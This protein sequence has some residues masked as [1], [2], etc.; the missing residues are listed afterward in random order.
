MNIWIAGAINPVV[1]GGVGRSMCNMARELEDRG[2]HIR[3]IYAP[4]RAL[5]HNYLLFSLFLAM[6]LCVAGS[7]K[8]SWII[9]RSTDTFFALL[10]AR[11]FCKNTRIALH[12]HGW[13]EMAYALEARLPNFIVQNPTTWKAHLIRFPVLRFLVK[14]VDACLCG[15]FSE[16][17][18]LAQKYPQCKSRLRY[19]PNGILKNNYRL[20]SGATLAKENPVFLCVGSTTWKKNISYA[21]A[22]FAHIHEEL[23]LA[24]LL[25]IGCPQSLLSQEIAGHSRA[26]DAITLIEAQSFATMETW[27]TKATYLLAT[28]RFEGGH[29]F[30]ILEAM[31][32][33]CI[34]IASDIP[35]H[36]E[37]IQ[38]Q[39]NGFIINGIAPHADA[40]SV[41]SHV[42]H[43]EYDMP[44]PNSS[45]LVEQN[46][47]RKDTLIDCALKTVARHS[48]CRQIDRLERILSV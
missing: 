42:M 17:R 9:G 47:L 46:T 1:A 44:L 40:R 28:S 41:V 29:P 10:V 5:V 43:L 21:I 34:V 24:R 2:H 26:I 14:N 16:M 32:A 48:L 12:S 25:L 19:F 13:E 3:L 18:Y 23:P 27:Y 35:A 20:Q 33:G 11:V 39:K 36:R 38:H 8:P 6:R 45:P 31:A 37:I 30:V 7:A 4:S 15:T 22:L